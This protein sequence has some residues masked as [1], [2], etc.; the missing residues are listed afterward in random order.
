MIQLI[1]DK[2]Y[3][4]KNRSEIQSNIKKAYNITNQKY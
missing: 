1:K 4:F 3:F 2:K